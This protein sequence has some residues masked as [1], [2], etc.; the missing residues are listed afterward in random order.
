MDNLSTKFY[1]FHISISE[2]IKKLMKS[3]GC[4]DKLLLW[5]RKAV[6]LNADKEKYHTF[7]P[8]A[9]DGFIL[10]YIDTILILCK[11]FVGTFTKYGNFLNKINCFYLI[12]DAQIDNAKDKI[13]KVEHEVEKEV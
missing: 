1:N 13:D 6:S 7:T 10:N 2:V 8:L 9:S 3:S 4:K 12:N 5:L 11:P